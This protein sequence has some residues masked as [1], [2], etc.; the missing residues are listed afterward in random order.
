MFARRV[1]KT[2]NAEKAIPPRKSFKP[3]LS[4]G[5]VCWSNFADDS[6]GEG[7]VEGDDAVGIW[8]EGVAS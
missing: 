7:M 6:D 2:E 8:F 5:F 1:M 4:L 3:V